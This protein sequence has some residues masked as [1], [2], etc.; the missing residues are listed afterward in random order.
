MA[1][2]TPLVDMVNDRFW[3]KWARTTVET[4]Y[5]KRQAAGEK[6]VTAVG[7]FWTVY[8]AVAVA[9][10][11]LVDRDLSRPETA[12]VFLPTA[13]LIAAYL[14]GTWTTL[15]VDLQFE[16]ASPED[17]TDAYNQMIL[18]KRDRLRWALGFTVAGGLAVVLAGAVLAASEPSA[19]KADFAVDIEAEG[20][21]TVLLVTGEFP[22]ADEVT[23]RVEP[24]EPK[25]G[26]QP[27]SFLVRPG[28]D[29]KVEDRQ[30]LVG[31]AKSY[32]VTAVWTKDKAEHALTKTVAPD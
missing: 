3:L 24:T 18:A 6:I 28:G 22:A 15:P 5:D 32:E 31:S 14:V 20:T 7:W 30:A 23:F 4:S 27:T 9:G 26:A 21:A 13:V 11:T 16:P 10:T 25:D 17:A 2:P 1:E 12:L 19:A 29:E 8:T